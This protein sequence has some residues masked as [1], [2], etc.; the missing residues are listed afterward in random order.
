MSGANKVQG[1]GFTRDI[2]NKLDAKYKNTDEAELSDWF[3]ALGLGR[4]EGLGRDHFQNFL[5][6]GTVLCALANS[7]QPGSIKRIHNPAN[8]KIAAMKSMKM[9]ENISFFLKWARSYGLTENDLFQTVSLFEGSN[10]SQVQITL[11]KVGSEAKS[12]NYNGPTIGIKVAQENKRSFTAEQLK[13]GEFIPAQT[14]GS[15][16]GASAAGSTPYGLGRQIINTQAE[17]TTHSN[18]PIL[19]SGENKPSKGT[20]GMTA[21]GT[22]RQIL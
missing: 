22:H 9:Q 1:Y 8:I 7:L 17:A 21:P 10:M 16:I 5:Q 4:P 14:S 15:N 19:M 12:K 6:D 18:A 13:A 2:Q 11:F 3:Q 20:S